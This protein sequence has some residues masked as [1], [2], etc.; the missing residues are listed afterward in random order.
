GDSAA[1]L[2]PSS[3]H[4]LSQFPVGATPIAVVS[5]DTAAWTL[6]A[7]GQTISRVEPGGGRPLTKAAPGTPTGLALGGGLLWVS[8]A[9]RN[10]G[11]TRAGIAA[12][13][14]STL[15]VRLGLEKLLP[16]VGPNS[17]EAPA[18]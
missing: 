11:E 1:L 12:L 6:D 18:V 7:D 10:R 4:L 15:S 9:D 2:D 14:P 5:D 17:G 8:F 13:D 3:G 16:G